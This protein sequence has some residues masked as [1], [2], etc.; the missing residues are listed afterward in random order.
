MKLLLFSNDLMIGA[1]VEG[2]ARQHGL[3][4]VTVGNQAVAIDA[5][6]ED[7]CRL[8]VVDLRMPSLDVRALVKAVRDCRDDNLPIVACA[9]HVHEA[10]LAAAREAG[11]DAVITRGQLDRELGE[12]VSRLTR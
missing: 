5:V 8:L 9:P 2:A 6:R 10:K 7:D 1:R 3:T 11:C 4:M 12:I